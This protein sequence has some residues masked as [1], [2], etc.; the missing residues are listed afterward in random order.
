MYVLG[1]LLVCL[2]V[3]YEYPKPGLFLHSFA[4]QIFVNI[5]SI[6]GQCSKPGGCS[7]EGSPCIPVEKSLETAIILLV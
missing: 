6:P 3:L 2:G 7:S 1:V 4:Q 5:H